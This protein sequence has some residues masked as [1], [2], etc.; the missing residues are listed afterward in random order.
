VRSFLAIVAGV[1]L[2]PAA[3]AGRGLVFTA[4]AGETLH[5]STEAGDK[6]YAADATT[7]NS[8]GI[9]Y[10]RETAPREAGRW[11]SLGSAKGGV[12]P[13]TIHVPRDAE[14]GEHFAGIVTGSG[15]VGVEIDVAGPRVARF[16]LGGATA[17]RRRVYLRVSN[18]GNIAAR[19]QGVVSIERRN[20][21]AFAR[22][23]FRMA[24]FLPHT[25]IDYPLALRTRLRPGAYV[26]NVKL[27]YPGADA[28][29]LQS[30]SAAPEFAVSNSPRRAA[31]APPSQGMQPQPEAAHGG[32]AW[33]WVVGAALTLL[34]AAAVAGAV[35]LW[36]RRPVSVTV[37]PLDTPAPTVEPCAGHHYWEVDWDSARPDPGG[38]VSYVHRCRR[39][40]LE[41]RAA[42]IGEAAT[43]APS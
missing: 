3:T 8:T 35:M 36:R 41:V 31:P 11:I 27:T 32:S 43:K 25:S 7:R 1:L 4:N 24:T 29:G 6:P 34:A 22:I 40:G 12:V 2:V 28:G 20:G 33:P 30:S 37:R 38:D 26:A 39:C 9:A 18:T 23:A 15:V 42:D 14:P 10:R 13:F 19:P 16:V 17:D 5:G 21:A